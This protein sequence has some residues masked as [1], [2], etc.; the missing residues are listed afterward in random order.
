[1]AGICTL[2]N[3]TWFWAHLSVPLNLYLN[4]FVLFCR[5]RG[6]DPTDTVYLATS[7]DIGHISAVS[8][9]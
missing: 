6:L 2:P 1:M 8:V 9:M 7:V 5:A 3:N 4:W